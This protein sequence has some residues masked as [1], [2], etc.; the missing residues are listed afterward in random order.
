M[1]VPP[2]GLKHVVVKEIE[3]KEKHISVAIDGT[4]IEI[5]AHSL[6]LLPRGWL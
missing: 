6:C 5:V 4:F 3:I 1:Y 2:E